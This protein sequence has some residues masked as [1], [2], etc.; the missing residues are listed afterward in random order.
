MLCRFKAGPEDAGMRLDRFLAE[1]ACEF[2]RTTLQHLIKDG[3]LLL[4]RVRVTI[5]KTKIG[6]GDILE[7]D[8]PA[9]EPLSLNPESIALDIIF[10]DNSILVINKPAGM[11]VHPGAG[12]ETGTMVHALLHH[13]HDLSGIGGKLR[14]GIVHR[15][16]KDTSG[17]IVV[18]KNDMAHQA[19]ARQFS[20]RKITKCYI[21]VVAGR[22]N[23]LS[24]IIESPVGRHPIHRKKMAAGV[25]RGK[26]AMTRW[27][28]KKE[29]AGA[30]LLGIRILTGRTH[31][32]R[33]HM[34]SLNHP[35]LGDLLYGGPSVIRLQGGNI[36]IARQML[37][38]AELGIRHP[39]S[40]ERMHW[41]ASV[42]S[43]M[44]QVIA[45]LSP[46]RRD[47]MGN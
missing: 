30:S 25:S 22:M 2:S 42:P 21:T 18:A 32:I 23:D 24:G 40:G 7:L 19:L 15:L 14:P 43:D 31:Q 20:N 12:H 9:P 26:I 28:L 47:S 5:P 36:E 16:D 34:A 8:I 3:R 13:C 38:A 27:T 46:P 11:V 1:R 39:V 17:L 33:V 29:L 45:A 6:T 41:Q 4:N 35:V 37:H 10:E 44:K